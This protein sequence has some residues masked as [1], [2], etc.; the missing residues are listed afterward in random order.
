MGADTISSSLVFHSLQDR[1]READSNA[2]V[3]LRE[4]YQQWKQRAAERDAQNPAVFVEQESFIV[5][6]GKVVAVAAAVA[7]AAAVY[8]A[9]S[10]QSPTPDVLRKVRE[11][12]PWE[13][14]DSPQSLA[15][16][17]EANLHRAGDPAREAAVR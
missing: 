13:S 12:L 5:S 16:E 15:R 3:P 7:A 2:T 1:L 6:I 14:S 17:M 9:L 10:S 4:A 8:K 11:A